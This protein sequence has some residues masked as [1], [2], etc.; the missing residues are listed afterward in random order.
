MYFLVL[1]NILKYNKIEQNRTELYMEDIE[2]KIIEG[3]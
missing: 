1:K 3:E 2:Y